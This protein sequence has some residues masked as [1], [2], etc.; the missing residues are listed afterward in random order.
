MHGR[1]I[2]IVGSSHLHAERLDI[3][4]LE[5]WE[6]W[7]MNGLFHGYED[8]GW[9]R[10][11]ELHHF[12]RTGSAYVRR[13]ERE[14]SGYRNINRYLKAIDALNLPVYMQKSLAIVKASE[15][16][17]FKPIMKTFCTQYFGCSF[18]WM[19]AHALYEHLH[20]LKV[21]KIA[22]YSID[23]PVQEYYFQRPTTEY[24]IG[25][26]QG[27]GIEVELSPY[28]TVLKAPY[29]YGYKENFNC[30]RVN[31]VSLVR[32]LVTQAAIPMQV[33]FEGI[34]HGTTVQDDR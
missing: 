24:F 14:Y 32:N 11:Y 29:I 27:M 2:A 30:I 13:G 12:T 5:G 34:Y 9:T 8:L 31:Y 16:F 4:N 10:W 15:P 17:P 19:I 18:A 28:T 1:K 3:A 6:K 23:F 33:M 20:G 7:S 26:A 25:M 21:S 22:L